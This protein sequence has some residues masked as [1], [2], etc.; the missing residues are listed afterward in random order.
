[1]SRLTLQKRKD[2]RDDQD[3]W[4]FMLGDLFYAFSDFGGSTSKELATIGL[5]WI[6]QGYGNPFDG[7]DPNNYGPVLEEIE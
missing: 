6:K 4:G 5:D 3:T 2:P 7:E 1:M